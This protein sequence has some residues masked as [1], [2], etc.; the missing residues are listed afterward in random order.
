[1]TTRTFIRPLL[2]ATLAVTGLAASGCRDTRSDKTPHQF[3]PDMDDQPKWNPQTKSEFFADQRTMRQPVKGTVAFG[4]VRFVSDADW[5]QPFMEERDVFL[6]EDDRVYLGTSSDGHYLADIPV[7]VDERL[8]LRGQERFNIYCSAC[9]G[10]DGAGTG[11]V[12]QQWSYPLPTFHDV[13]YLDK[14]LA[15]GKALDGYIFHVIRNGVV[16]EGVQKMPS[17]AHALDE[18]DAWAVV[19][20]IRTLQASHRGTIGD[21]AEA[22][23]VELERRRPAKAATPA[24]GTPGTT[25]AAPATG[26]TPATP[27][28]PAPAPA[29]S[30]K[31]GAHP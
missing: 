1:M 20:Y 15:D 13:K 19:A 25:P 29:G 7:K 9:H 22:D 12:G 17:Y 2:A 24:P 5:A 27:A 21:V 26:T 8:I 4:R 31:T 14:S 23:R 11:M 3:F 16:S 6:K 18:H 10:Y 30:G 28:A